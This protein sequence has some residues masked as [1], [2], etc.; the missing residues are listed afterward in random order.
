MSFV[1]MRFITTSYSFSSAA[2]AS[3]ESPSCKIHIICNILRMAYTEM[4][5]NVCVC[6]CVCMCMC[7]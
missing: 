6:V 5:S 3:M 2:T 1:V 4:H 7:M